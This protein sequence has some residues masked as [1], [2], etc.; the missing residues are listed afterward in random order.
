MN[1]KIISKKLAVA[2]LA[3]TMSALPS[4][5]ANAQAA[6]GTILGVSTTAAVTAVVVVAV[7]FGVAEANQGTD[8]S[9]RAEF[10]AG[11]IISPDTSGDSAPTTTTTTTN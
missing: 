3:M 8:D 9:P 5:N 6:A 1:V 10:E 7:V 4:M 2:L 11:D